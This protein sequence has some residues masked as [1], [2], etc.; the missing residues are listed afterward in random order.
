M[1]KYRGYEACSKALNNVLND[2]K[3]KLKNATQDNIVQVVDEVSEELVKFTARSEPIN[4]TN[5]EEIE[6]IEKLDALA[7]ATRQ[8]ITAES[9]ESSVRVIM[10]STSQLNQLVKKL[11]SEVEINK[12]KAK[13]IRLK[14]VIA[15]VDS[16][17]LVIEELKE[18]KMS[19]SSE[20]SEDDILKHINS[21]VKAFQSLDKAIKAK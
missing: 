14:P 10:D 6:Q 2:S 5:W 8:A 19:L 9:I 11:K 7:D 1:S 3:T 12:Q 20:N 18:S 16:L 4:Y 21:L 13:E 15:V 17:A